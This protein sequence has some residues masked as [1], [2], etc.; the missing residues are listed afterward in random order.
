MATIYRRHK[1][2]WFKYYKDG[3]E[4]RHS[5]GTESKRAALIE[6]ARIEREMLEGAHVEQQLHEI[7]ATVQAYCECLEAIGRKSC[8]QANTHRNSSPTALLRR[9]TIDMQPRAFILPSA[10]R[11]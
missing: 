3:K 8:Y 9:K 11:L 4:H 5:L 1:T 6:K 2:W 10:R 7:P